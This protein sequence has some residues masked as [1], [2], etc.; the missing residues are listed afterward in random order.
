MYTSTTAVLKKV[1][2]SVNKNNR[3]ETANVSEF[4]NTTIL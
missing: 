3:N 1:I 4:L 2:N